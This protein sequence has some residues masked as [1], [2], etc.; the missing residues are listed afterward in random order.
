MFGSVFSDFALENCSFSGFGVFPD[1]RVFSNLVFGFRFSST[2]MAVF[3]ILW[4]SAFYGFSGFAKE[5]TPRS[6][7]KTG[8]SFQGTMYIAFYPF[9]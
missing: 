4:S 1:L 2:K 3:R 9:F 7:A 6:R 8:Q 5:V